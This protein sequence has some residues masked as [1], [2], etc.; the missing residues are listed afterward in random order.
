VLQA[1][2]LSGDPVVVGVM[3]GCRRR[4]RLQAMQEGGDAGGNRK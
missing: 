4:L 3:F 1:A 2:S